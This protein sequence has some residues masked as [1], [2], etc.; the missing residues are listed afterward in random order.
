MSYGPAS[1]NLNA[2]RNVGA[3]G[4]V[5]SGDPHK[6]VQALFATALERIAAARGCMERS[7]VAQKGE[8]VS[9]AIGI[10]GALNDALDM[11]KGGEI[12]ANLRELYDYAC[13][14]LAEANAFND[15][16]RLDEVAA[17][18][19]EIKSAWDALPLS[20]TQPGR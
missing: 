20:G 16:A 14:R 15:A 4:T 19:R 13:R 7:E 10:L 3:Y 1:S 5:E 9:K 8:N 2:Y 6:L 18:V 11:E 17:L 12:A